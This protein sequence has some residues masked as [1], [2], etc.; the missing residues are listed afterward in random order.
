MTVG[1]H[2]PDL[3]TP[4]GEFHFQGRQVSE[5]HSLGT[6]EQWSERDEQDEVAEGRL[7]RRRGAHGGALDAKEGRLQGEKAVAA[8]VALDEGGRCD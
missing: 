4:L 6:V 5:L 8:S 3:A 7:T 2:P 1:G